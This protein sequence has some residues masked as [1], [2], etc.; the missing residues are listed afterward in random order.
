LRNTIL[1]LLEY[2]N[3]T[4]ISIPMMLTTASYREKVVAKIKDPIVK[5]FW[6]NEFGSWDPKNQAE[7]VA[8]V[9]NKVGQFLSSP[10]LRNVL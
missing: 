4:L 6:V 9:L 7:Y 1:A 2:P 3:T 5:K 8:P 10:I